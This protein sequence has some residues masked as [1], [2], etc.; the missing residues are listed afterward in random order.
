VFVVTVVVVAHAYHVAG[1]FNGTA[2][3]SCNG[4]DET[5][6]AT[7]IKLSSSQRAAGI[8]NYAR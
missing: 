2:D 5:T 3:A 1:G 6:T 7:L 4:H 8:G